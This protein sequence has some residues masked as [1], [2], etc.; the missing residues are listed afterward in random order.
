MTP[1]GGPQ[2]DAHECESDEREQHERPTARA[3]TERS[4]DGV[5]AD[6]ARPAREAREEG[7]GDQGAS[8]VNEFGFTVGDASRDD[9]GGIGVG[10][11]DQRGVE[12][13]AGHWDGT[14]DDSHAVEAL[15]ARGQS[16]AAHAHDEGPGLADRLL[17]HQV[18]VADH[19]VKGQVRLQGNVRSPVDGEHVGGR[20]RAPTGEGTQLNGR[21]R[22]SS[23][24]QDRATAKP[25]ELGNVLASQDGGSV[26]GQVVLDRAL[27]AGEQRRGISDLNVEVLALHGRARRDNGALEQHCAP[28]NRHFLPLAQRHDVLAEVVHEGNLRVEDE[29][30]THRGHSARQ[31]RLGVQDGGWLARHKRSGALLVQVRDV[32][33]GDIAALQARRQVLGAVVDTD[34]PRPGV[35]CC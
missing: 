5:R 34:P 25:G 7:G 13:G 17:A 30:G 14:V 20:L 23:D 3:G 10:R 28:G 6:E 32:N 33:D 18:G 12:R 8:C 11:N 31:G 26:F 4:C 29:P 1:G 21:V 22:G 9:G 24:E 27:E 2:S 35:C 15:G 19:S 16:V